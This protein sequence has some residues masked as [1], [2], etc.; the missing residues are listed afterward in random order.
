MPLGFLKILRNS[1]IQVHNYKNVCLLVL[2]TFQNKN[3]REK[4]GVIG[5]IIS[6]VGIY[7]FTQRKKIG[8]SLYGPI[9]AIGGGLVI[10]ISSMLFRV[11]MNALGFTCLMLFY[12]L[13]V[14][15]LFF[16]VKKNKLWKKLFGLCA[17][18]L[19][20][21]I[22]FIINAP[23]QK[24][25]QSSEKSKSEKVIETSGKEANKNEKATKDKIVEIASKEND[26]SDSNKVEKKQNVPSTSK[27][28]TDE[29]KNGNLIP[30][31]FSNN[32]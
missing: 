28:L 23:V 30:V 1:L 21:T 13:L 12:Y 6:I 29:V 9:T 3:Q 7:Y 19:I 4:L 10:S 14:S 16:F 2:R 15:A 22:I 20:L 32:N 8:F 5:L 24:T 11:W 27:Q 17:A 26:N 31:N 25:E 18:I